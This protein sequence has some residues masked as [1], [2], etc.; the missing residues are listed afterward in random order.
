M[1]FPKYLLLTLFEDSIKGQMVL[2]YESLEAVV[3]SLRHKVSQSVT[4]VIKGSWKVDEI[5]LELSGTI[6]L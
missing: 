4:R 1:V 6:D 2:E 3:M 5:H